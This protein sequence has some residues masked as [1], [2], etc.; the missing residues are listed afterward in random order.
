MVAALEDHPHPVE[1]ALVEL[2]SLLRQAVG[3]PAWSLDDEQLVEQVVQAGAVVAQAQA[4]LL[5]LIG[6]ADAREALLRDGA[7]SAQAWVRHRLRLSP[8]EASSYVRTGRALRSELEQTAQACGTGELGLG[9]AVT[10][11]RTVAGLP[12]DPGLRR[13]AE[14]DLVAHAGVFD[15]VVLARL[16]RRLLAV[17][18]PDDADAREGDALARA[19]ERAARHLDLALVPDGEGGAWLRGRLD[20]EGSAVVRGRAGPAVRAAAGRG[21]QTRPA[22]PRAAPGRSSGRGVPADAGGRNAPDDGW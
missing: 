4:L 12:A 9:H 11:A 10:I 8:A 20:P 7:P 13:S 14:R 22:T 18:D 19:E 15:P 1:G 17:V 21:G 2:R 3:S 5:R 6:E 16:G